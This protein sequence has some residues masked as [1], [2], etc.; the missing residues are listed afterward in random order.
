MKN[1]RCRWIN[2]TGLEWLWLSTSISCSTQTQQCKFPTVY[3]TALQSN[4]YWLSPCPSNEGK[5]KSEAFKVSLQALLRLSI[6]IFSIFLLAKI[7]NEIN[8]TRLLFQPKTSKS[9]LP[10]AETHITKT[11]KSIKFATRESS[12]HWQNRTLKPAVSALK[13]ISYLFYDLCFICFHNL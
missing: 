12:Y 11:L 9:S 10:V 8:G 6:T 7:S 2:N 4:T 3:K 1:T 13:V 5:N